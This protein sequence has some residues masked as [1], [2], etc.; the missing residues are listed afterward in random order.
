MAGGKETPRQKMIGMMYLVLTALLAL[1]VSKSILDAFVAIE[2]NTQ[3]SAIVQL[4]RGNIFVSDLKSG[5]VQNKTENPGKAAKCQYYLDL[6]AKIDV[7]AAN[8]IKFID[9]IK[10]DIMKKSGEAVDTEK[11]QDKETI[12]WKKYTATDKLRPARLNL[13]AVQAKD[14]YDVPMHEIIGEEINN[15][16][17]DKAGMKLWKMYNGFRASVV[18]TL[19]TY[20]DK[21]DSISGKGIGAPKFVVKTTPIN[22]YKDNKD[23]DAQVNAML[24]KTQCNKED[25]GVLKQLY[26]E[27]TKEERFEEVNEVKNVHWIGKTF[28]HSPLVAALASLTA[29]QLEILNAR[30]TA[31]GYLSSK[32]VTAEFSFNKLI[33]LATATPSV[34]SPGDP[35]EISVVMG[36]YDSDNQ[37]TVTGGSFTV[38]NGKGVMKTTAGSADMSFTGTIAIKSRSGAV[39]EEKWEAKV[40]VLT[41]EKEAAIETPE[42]Q[43]FYE[44][45]PIELK[46]SA[47]GMYKNV[48]MS[49]PSPYT[50]AAGSAGS[51]V[52]VTLSG[53]DSKGSSVSLGSKKFT[54]KK[55]PKPELVWNGVTTGGKANKNGGGLM[56]RYDNNVP[57]SPSKGKFAIVNY[58]ITFPG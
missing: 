31:A 48:R 33:A 51:I 17:A 3:K 49:V 53:T 39:K 5:I 19:G 45:I 22:K 14:Q 7:E 50:A 20:H 34:A 10:I 18:E 47:T 11:N 9:E 24:D 13:M 46:A 30:A 25:R 56:C 29:M 43:V 16:A 55:A 23:L 35:I 40:G 36:A 42:M 21:I 58:A 4:D 41:S 26:M 52:T 8:M 2:E 15:P 28:D 1:N 44:G 38:S 57:F 27:L 12:V 54:V 32:V 6:I 37:P